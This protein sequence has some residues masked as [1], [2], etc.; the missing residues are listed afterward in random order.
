MCT[1][2]QQVHLDSDISQQ[3]EHLSIRSTRACIVG[4]DEDINEGA[5]L[6]VY[7]GKNNGLPT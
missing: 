4:Y 3:Y 5:S 2:D 7:L 6:Y 1:P